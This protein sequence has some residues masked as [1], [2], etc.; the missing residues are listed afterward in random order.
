LQDPSKES[1]DNLSNVQ[2]EASRHL[3]NKEREYLKNRINKLESTN[4]TKNIRE[5]YRGIHEFKKGYQSRTN[6]IRTR[7]AIYL[8]ILIKF[9][10]G[11]RI[12][13]VSC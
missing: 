10:M 1:E 7:E 12:T 8:W 4:K 2:W 13:S 11:G 6:L 5:L 9:G 3:R